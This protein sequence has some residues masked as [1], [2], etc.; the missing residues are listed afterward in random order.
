MVAAIKGPMPHTDE[1][2][3]LRRFDPGRTDR[4]VLFG[5]SEAPAACGQSPYMTQLELYLIKRGEYVDEIDEQRVRMGREIEPIVLR[6]YRT[7]TGA[8]LQFRH[9]MYL[10]PQHQFMAATPDATAYMPGQTKELGRWVVDGKN[11]THH[12]LSSSDDDDPHKFG[13]EGTDEVPIQYLIQGQQ[14]CEV[15]G[16]PRCVFAVLVNGWELKTYTVDRNDELIGQI[17]QCE[18]ELAERIINGDPPEP[19]YS[20]RGTQDLLENLYEIRPNTEKVVTDPQI[21]RDFQTWEH[22]KSVRSQLDGT[23]RYLRNRILQE[24][25]EFERLIMGDTG[26]QSTRSVMKE[27]LWKEKDIAKLEPGSVKRAASHQLRGSAVKKKK[28]D[29]TDG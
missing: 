8:I 21:I 5:A 12:M 24:H 26:R 23:I 19:D 2:Y 9:P 28:A 1:W 20:H 15:M 22:L 27:S 7:Q 14:L 18:R 13:E 10:H 11:T 16:M 6:E 17:V 29:T 3:D 4:P 25:G